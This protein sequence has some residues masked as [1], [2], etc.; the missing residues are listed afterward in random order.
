MSVIL[1]SNVK[2]K[3][4]TVSQLLTSDTGLGYNRRDA[5]WYGIKIHDDDSKTVE[6]L[7][8]SLTPGVG[9]SHERLHGITSATDHAAASEA[10][11]GKLVATNV[12]TGAIEFIAKDYD[13]YQSFNVIV[14]AESAYPVHNS[15]SGQGLKFSAGS[16][17]ALASS[18]SSEGVL[19]IS[20]SAETNPGTVTSVGLTMPSQFVVSNSPVMGSGSLA[21]AWN[22]QTAAMVLASPTAVAG[23]PSFR[24]LVAT[25]IPALPYDNYGSWDLEYF[26]GETGYITTP[27]TTGLNV[28]FVNAGVAVEAGRVTVTFPESNP[29]YAKLDST[30]TTTNT[31]GVDV[32]GLSLSVVSGA[33]YEFE[34]LLQVGST[35]TNGNGYGVGLSESGSAVAQIFGNYT[36]ATYLNF[37]A[38]HNNL[39]GALTVWNGNGGFVKI[40]GIVSPTSNG[41][42]SIKHKKYSS[43][44]AS[45]FAGSFLKLTRIS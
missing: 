30:V 29:V 5:L 32:T 35:D 4:P 22:S 12:L 39:Y 16:H 6:C 43:G 14:N 26:D 10:D 38:L 45:V 1:I 8:E 24:F 33:I 41:N 11:Y 42:I 19:E 36:S 9:E 2:G 44:T 18:L 37:Y 23:V 31:T 28:K 25:D 20:I 3:K 15:A 13:N 34:A 7:G 27:I 17:V 40:K 21:A